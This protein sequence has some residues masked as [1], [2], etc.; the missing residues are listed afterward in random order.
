M[1]HASGFAFHQASP[2][3]DPEHTPP[4]GGADMEG[5]LAIG[6]VVANAALWALGAV[7]P[8][9]PRPFVDLSAEDVYAYL[10][11]EPFADWCAGIPTRERQ[12]DPAKPSMVA[13][14]LVWLLPCAD[15]AVMVSPREDHQWERW[16][17]VM[18][19]PP[20]TLDAALCGDRTIRASN[21]TLIGQKMS[22]WSAQQKA[23]DVF[24]KAQAQRVACFP[25]SS[26]KDMVGNVQLVER[27]FY[28]KLRLSSDLVIAAA[29]LPFE[30]R[31]TGGA[32]L[33]RG[34][35]VAAPALGEANRAMLGDTLGQGA[36][37]RRAP[38]TA[39]VTSLTP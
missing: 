4:T 31:T 11:V 24:G 38:G 28:S 15:G 7:E 3:S 33:E 12:R 27:G 18:G 34:G 6:I 22:E 36:Q 13:G 14:G 30:L 35:E 32:T 19:H 25:V 10:L 37:G 23:Q 29:G 2:V 21:A 26:A 1:Q 8:G 20:W 9:Q 5:A 39:S 17:E 16:T